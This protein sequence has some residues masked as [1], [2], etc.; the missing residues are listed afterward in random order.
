VLEKA[1]NGWSRGGGGRSGRVRRGG[2]R[3]MAGEK[4]RARKEEDLGSCG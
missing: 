1:S 2:A 4:E 3:A